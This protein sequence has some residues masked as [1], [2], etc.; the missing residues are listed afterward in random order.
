M[1]EVAE[2]FPPAKL[3]FRPLEPTLRS[4]VV[5]LSVVK[6]PESMMS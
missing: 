5:S 6:L 2:R 3:E 4:S 1:V